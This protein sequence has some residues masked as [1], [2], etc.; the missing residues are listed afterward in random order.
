MPL[1]RTTVKRLYLN[2]ISLF[3]N[4]LSFLSWLPTWNNHNCG[5]FFDHL[6]R[7]N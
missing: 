7:H 4:F 5:W 2:F 6:H 1:F 3:V